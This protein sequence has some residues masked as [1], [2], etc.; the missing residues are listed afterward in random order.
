M[1]AIMP[2]PTINHL[3]RALAT[4]RRHLREPPRKKRRYQTMTPIF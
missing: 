1:H 3:R 4:L 2:Q